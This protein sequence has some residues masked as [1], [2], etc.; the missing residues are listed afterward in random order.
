[1]RD[2]G[3]VDEVASEAERGYAGSL[4]NGDQPRVNQALLLRASIYRMR[5]EM[6]RAQDMLS[7]LEPRLRSLPPGNIFLASLLSEQA[8]M[9]QARGDLSTAL[10][11]IDQAL[12]IA[13]ASVESGQLG[14]D[15]VP[16]TRSA[17]ATHCR[18]RPSRGRPAQGL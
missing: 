4:K 11:Q 15:L 12:P 2:L 10:N 6:T 3:R 7:E 14:A 17:S 13:E 18:G 9:A 1:L 8:L 16:V 5:G